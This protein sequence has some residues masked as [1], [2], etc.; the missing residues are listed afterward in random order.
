[1][2]VGL[3]ANLTDDAVAGGPAGLRA[4]YERV[5]R[6]LVEKQVEPG[7]RMDAVRRSAEL[8]KAWESIGEFAATTLRAE[9]TLDERGLVARLETLDLD[10]FFCRKT[11]FRVDHD[12]RETGFEEE[13]S[14]RGICRADGARYDA[15]F[16]P[17]GCQ[18]PLP[19]G[20]IEG[21]VVFGQY[22]R[23]TK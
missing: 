22:N 1:L 8:Q 15:R 10:W 16:R 11:L 23:I 17:G 14:A 6:Q 19:G 12:C 18:V 4:E 13:Q 2:A 21:G 7:D 5:W 9:P 20:R 3:L